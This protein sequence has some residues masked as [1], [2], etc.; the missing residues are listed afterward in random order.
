MGDQDL[1]FGAVI[2]V[3][4]ARVPSTARRLEQD[5]W[6]I[7]ATG[8]HVSFH[9]PTA[10]AFV[11]LAAAAATTTHVRL[12]S[13]VTLLPLYPAALAA[14]MV[15][16]VDNISGGRFILGVGVG[17]EN[18]REFEACGVPLD[19][20]GARTDESLRMMRRL[21]T[22]HAVSFSGEFARLDEVA[23][24]PPPVQRPHPPIW[25]AGRKRGAIERA[26]REGDGWL[27]YM[28]SPEMLSES[29]AVI[30][31]LRLGRAPIEGGSFL[32]SCVHEDRDVAVRCARETLGGTY[33]QDATP[34]LDK[35]LVVG[36]PDDVTERVRQ[37]IDAGARLI[38]FAA[39]CPASYVEQHLSLLS[40]EVLPRLRSVR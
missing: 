31:A 16:A 32:W 21:W 37:Y 38:I 10:N 33:R 5:G 2:E 27:P 18:P 7:V 30:A 29:L 39:A 17:G 9:V 6:D 35:Y 14:K 24:E 34:W 11:T 26:A 3:T 25:I 1:R 4:D 40:R 28:Y 15:A 13:S 20:R 23:L 22:G 12:M 36:T 19:E 8:E